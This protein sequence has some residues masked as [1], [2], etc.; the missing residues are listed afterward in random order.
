MNPIKVNSMCAGLS[1]ALLVITTAILLTCARAH[2]NDIQ[3]EL[4]TKDSSDGGK[5]YAVRLKNN[6]K[7]PITFQMLPDRGFG[8]SACTPGSLFATSVSSWNTGSRRWEP[9]DTF[10]SGLKTSVK[11]DFVTDAFIL[12]PG[13]SVCGGW[14]ADSDNT[15]PGEELRMTVCTSFRVHSRCF[16]SPSFRV[17]SAQKK[18]L[19]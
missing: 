7:E 5:Q 6:S 2:E 3:V 13:G 8:H 10:I 9:R 16:T 11:G 14:W 4:L 17:P 18:T 19:R 12:Q 1:T 15:K